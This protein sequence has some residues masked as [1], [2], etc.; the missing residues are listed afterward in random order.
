MR[1]VLLTLLLVPVVRA[2]GISPEEI[3]A[4]LTA[5]PVTVGDVEQTRQLSGFELPLQSR[6]H[7]VFWQD[8]G[9]YLET[10]QPF[11]N[12]TTLTADAIWH[13]NEDGSLSPASQLGNAVQ[14]EV[15]RTLLAFFSADLPLIRSRFEPHWQ[16]TSATDWTVTLIPRHAM[17]AAHVE[18]VELSGG[19]FLDRLVL[20]AANGDT[21]RLQF[22]NVAF[23]QA[24]DL[25]QCRRFFQR[26]EAC[27]SVTLME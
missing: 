14:K 25:S 27:D 1:G 12:A 3:A 20:V 23:Q 18:S 22:S 8:H 24:P 26:D 11:F 6:G 17:I 16:I 15:N 10:R 7:F 19:A 2:W 9:L 5:Q 13:W 4:R 21:S